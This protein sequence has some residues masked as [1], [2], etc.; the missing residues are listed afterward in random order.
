[1]KKLFILLS[2]SI[3]FVSCDEK[4]NQVIIPL[5]GGN[6]NISAQATCGPVTLSNGVF[7]T[8]SFNA[9]SFDTD[10]IHDTTANQSRL[11]VNTPGLY[12]IT[13]YANFHSNTTGIRF[14]GV[15]LNNVTA[16]YTT[17]VGASSQLETAFTLSGLYRFNQGDYIEL[18]TMQTSGG[19]LFL[20]P[21]SLSIVRM[22]D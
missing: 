2:L 14:I 22:G 18:F 15:R 21:A 1:M 19:D 9:E 12:L 13:A 5:S 6:T 10:N 8:L 17:N 4:T 20:N 16:I 7:A 3:L 11:T